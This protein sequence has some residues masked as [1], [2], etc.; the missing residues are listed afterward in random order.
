M[1]F[2]ENRKY[3]KMGY[4]GTIYR[5]HTWHLDCIKNGFACVIEEVLMELFLVKVAVQEEEEPA[6]TTAED[7]FGFW[8]PVKFNV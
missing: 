4:V 7:I 3:M 6:A 8:I 1:G 5:S 2:I